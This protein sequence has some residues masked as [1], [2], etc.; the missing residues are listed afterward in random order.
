M[1]ELPKGGVRQSGKEE[2]R[3][4]LLKTYLLRIR[5]EKGERAVRTI[6]ENAGI[7]P[8][9]VDNETGWVS[10]QAAKRAL[11]G[12]C[13]ALGMDAL[14]R[15]GPWVTNAEALGTHVRMLRTAEHPVDAYEYLADNAREVTRVGTWELHYPSDDAAKSGVKTASSKGG[16]DA[17]ATLELDGPAPTK[18][19]ARVHE[20]KLTYRPRSDGYDEQDKV[21]TSTEVLFCAAREGELSGIPRIWGLPD[22]EITHE[23]CLAKGNDCC[24]YR[25]VWQ[26]PTTK[27]GMVLG[28]VASGAVCGLAVGVAGGP[29]AG[30]LGGVLAGALGAGAGRLWENSKREAASRVFEKNRIAAL[31]RGLDLKGEATSTAVPGELTGTVL[32]GKYRIGKK[33]GSG[34][35]GVV[36]AAEHTTLGHEVAVKVLRGAAARDGGEI[37]RLRR[38]AYIQVHVDHPNVARV[39]DLDQMPDGS[40]YVVMERLHGRSL[41]DKLSRE[42]IVAPGF[43]LPVFIGVCRALSA[44]HKKGVVHRDLKPGNVFLCE[45]GGAKVLDFGMSKLTSAESLTQAGYTLGTPEYMAPEQCIGANVVAQTD[46]YA[47]GVLMY[48]ALTG[49]LPIVAQS[50]RELLDLH[51]RQIP[52][53]MR[54]R[55]PDLGIP[56]ALDLVVMK[57][58]KKRINDRPKTADDLEG[59]LSAIPLE[60]LPTSYSPRGRR[61]SIPQAHEESG[62][63]VPAIASEPPP[64]PP[65]AAAATEPHKF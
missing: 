38:E 50:R 41:A 12:I 57:C 3:A 54:Q 18:D 2:L 46:L 36:Y 19:K 45:G 59:M 25:V 64:P 30:V 53:P 56:E 61:G 20:V 6:L 27:N 29:I 1:S 60:G 55:R 52:V 22:A 5:A 63:T 14:R 24:T 26:L 21:D 58:L 40:M 65:G 13:E 44:A 37:A 48:E 62:A 33:I 51:Q 32:G 4:S 11:R 7:D 39:H 9:M 47:F 49:E 15:R 42:H 34:G 10:T 23:S 8:A 35:I 28:A 17:A 16:G 31:E 43:A